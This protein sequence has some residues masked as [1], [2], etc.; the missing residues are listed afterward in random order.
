MFVVERDKCPVR[1][2]FLGLR[3]TKKRQRKGHLTDAHYQHD[4]SADRDR[5]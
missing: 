2:A 3:H 5:R 4:A 1:K